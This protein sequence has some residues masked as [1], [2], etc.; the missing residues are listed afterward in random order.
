MKKYWKLF[1]ST[2][3]LSSFTFGGG[4]VI[5]PLMK[6]QFVDDL[7]WID[8]DEMTDL[9]AIA[10]SSPGSI[11]VNASILVGFKVAGFPGALVTTLGTMLPPLFILSIISLFYVEFR[12]NRYVGAALNAMQAGVAAVII[13]V[14]YTMAS[15]IIKTKKTLSLVIMVVSFIAASVFKVNVLI[16]IL[17]AGSIGAW[18]SLR[19]AKQ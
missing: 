8:E 11:A 10:Q 2:F 14:V 19:G 16:I 4:Y 9:V 5:I 7:G 18:S 1:S 17:F 13:D 12:D 3:Y 15:Q 6:K